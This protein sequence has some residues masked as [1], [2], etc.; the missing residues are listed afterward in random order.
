M[1]VIAAVIIAIALSVRDFEYVT[2]VQLL[3]EASIFAFLTLA[4]C[5]PGKKKIIS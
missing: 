5:D 3:F 2:G 1:G 4:I